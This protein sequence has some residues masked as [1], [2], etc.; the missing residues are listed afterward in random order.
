MR[1]TQIEAIPFKVPL[2]QSIGKI[3]SSIWSMEAANHVLIKISTDEGLE[4][5]GEAVE[6]PTI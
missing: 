3:T 5:F 2:A 6:R 1:I 4:G